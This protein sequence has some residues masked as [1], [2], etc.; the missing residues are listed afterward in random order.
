MLGRKSIRE[1]VGYVAIG[2]F[3]QR[4]LDELFTAEATPKAPPE[5]NTR[6]KLAL[7]SL[8][9]IEDP[10]AIEASSYSDLAFQSY[11]EF[12]ALQRLL[13][14]NKSAGLRTVTELKGTLKT[15]LEEEGKPS[16]RAKCI[17]Q[18]I[19]FFCDLAKIAAVS[20]EFPEEKIPPGIRKLASKLTHT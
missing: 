6:L 10:T 17:K 7:R 1:S 5:K 2:L 9:A 11:Q 20:A 8:D 12:N 19:V 4:V 3:S 13:R 16:R 18:A 14:T 15:I